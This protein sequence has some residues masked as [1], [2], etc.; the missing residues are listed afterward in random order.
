[1]QFNEK[2][3]SFQQ[4]IQIQLDIPMDNTGHINKCHTIHY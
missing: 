3:E 4:M 1:M 2:V